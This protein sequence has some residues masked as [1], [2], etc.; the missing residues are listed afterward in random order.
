MTEGPTEHTDER[1][2]LIP[3]LEGIRARF[4]KARETARRLATGL[5]DEQ[6]NRR[7]GQERWSVAECLDHLLQV[8]DRVGVSIDEAIERG[9][10]RG[11]HS[12]GPFRYGW[13]ERWFSRVS[14]GTARRRPGRVKTPAIYEPQRGRAV[15]AVLKEFDA[16]QVNLIERVEAADGLDLAKI[17]FRSPATPLVRMSLG[18]WLEMLAD[19][20]EHHFRQAEA[21]REA[22]LAAD[23]SR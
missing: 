8:G 1:R 4:L 19:H 14:S 21:A 22:A 3:E 23:P 17:R 6:F 13:F 9:H 5:S 12:R 16:L 10:R 2:E 20:Q 15:D 18:K 7:P 11:M